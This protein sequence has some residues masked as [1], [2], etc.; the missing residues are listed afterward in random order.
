MS[1][2]DIFVNKDSEGTDKWFTSVLGVVVH[3]D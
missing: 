1:S 3:T 2:E